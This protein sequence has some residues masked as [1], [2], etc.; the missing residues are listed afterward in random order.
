MTEAALEL[1]RQH[2]LLAEDM[3]EILRTAA[4]RDHWKTP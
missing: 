1:H 4:D 3:A 2:F